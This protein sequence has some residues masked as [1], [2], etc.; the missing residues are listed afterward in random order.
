MAQNANGGQLVFQAGV[1]GFDP[2]LRY[3]GKR[4]K[5]RWSLRWAVTPV[6]LGK[7]FDSTRFPPIMTCPYLWLK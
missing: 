2:R 5:V 4:N 7:E 3:H 1:S 6:P